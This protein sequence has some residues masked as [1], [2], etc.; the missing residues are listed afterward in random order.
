M[1]PKN[2]SMSSLCPGFGCFNCCIHQDVHRPT[3]ALGDY[4]RR[5]LFE[6][7]EEFRGAK[8]D[9]VIAEP[10]IYHHEIR[11]T[12]RYLILM[13]DGVLQNLKDCGVDDVPAEIQERLQVDISVR[14]TAQGLVDA[15]GRKHDIAYCRVTAYDFGKLQ[16][17]SFMLQSSSFPILHEI[18]ALSLLAS[19]RKVKTFVTDSN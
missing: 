11:D 17:L 14:S 10:D 9:P 15:I 12:W 4:F 7:K 19:V 3:R 16:P 6:E 5:N 18:A 13:S 8:S 1:M 2:F